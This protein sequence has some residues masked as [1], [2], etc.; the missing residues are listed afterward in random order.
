[1]TKYIFLISTWFDLVQ[2]HLWRFGHSQVFQWV[3]SGHLYVQTVPSLYIF[4]VHVHF[5]IVSKPWQNCFSSAEVKFWAIG[6]GS[7]KVTGGK[8]RTRVALERD[9]ELTVVAV[10]AVVVVV[11]AWLERS[12]PRAC[13]KLKNLPVCSGPP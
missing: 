10:V 3:A 4:S 6:V 12:L 9:S 11:V 5:S 2:W 8:F 13:R 1:M 7:T